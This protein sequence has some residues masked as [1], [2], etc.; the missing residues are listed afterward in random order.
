MGGGVRAGCAFHP[1]ARTTVY[2]PG[3]RAE[4]EWLAGRAAVWLEVWQEA[5]A[6]A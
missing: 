3:A 2:V 1:Y 4:G 6:K 5:A